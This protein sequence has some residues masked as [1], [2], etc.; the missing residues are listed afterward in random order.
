LWTLDH[1][2]DLASDFS[3]VH[4]IGD[5][6]ALDGPTFFRLAFRIGSY[7][8]VMR[9]LVMAEAAAERQQEPAGPV[10]ALPGRQVV[11]ASRAE[12]QSEPLFAQVFSFSEAKQAGG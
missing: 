10:G 4:G 1:L 3:A 6:M 11:G 7:Q 2:D 8:G 12:L 9:D 5:I